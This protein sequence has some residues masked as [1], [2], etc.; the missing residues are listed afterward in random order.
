MQRRRVLITVLLAGAL[1]GWLAASDWFPTKVHAQ[2]N[3]AEKPATGGALVLPAPEAPFGG[4]IGRKAKE[5]KP[6]FPKAVT[7][8][9]GAPNVLLIM[10]DDTGFGASSTFGGPIPTP[11][12]E[13][14][15]QRGLR[16]N[17]FHTTALCSPTRAALLTGRNHHSVGF[18]DI[19][20]FATGFPGYN[21]IMP[22]SAGTIGNIL[23][24]NGYNTSWFGKNHLIPD[25]LES[26]DGPF[27]QW[28]SG[29]GFEYFYGF[30]GGDTDNWHPALFE[31]TKPVLPPF[32]DPNYIL[33]RDMTDRAINWIRTQHAIAPDK[34]FFL[35]FAPGNGHA[36][37]HAT[38]D[39]IAKF[40]GK[41][42]YGWDKQREMTLENQKKLGIV[43]PDTVLT[44]RPKEIPAWD[45]LNADQKR[46]YAR[47]MEVYAAAVAQS[48]YEIGRLID[49]LE[50]SGQLDNTLVIYIEGDNGASGEGTLQGT[51]NEMG[52]GAPKPESLPFLV[53]MMDQLGGDRT[54]NHYPVGWAHA[55]DTPFQWTKQVAS[56]FGG[57]RNGMAVSWP[58]RIKAHGEIRPQFHHVIDVLPTILEA[59]G[60][61]APMMLNGTS[62]MPFEGV[63]MAY[64]FDDGKAPMRHT[65]QYF[66]IAANRGLY[67]DGWMASTT[68]LRFP[69]VVSGV[70]PDPDAFPW[71]LYNV[72]QDFSQSNNLAKQNP[73]KLEELK[74]LFLI[75]A[76]R[77]N[78]LPIDSS[79]AD[80]ANPAL[81]PNFNTGRTEFT[82][83]PG[84]IRI[85]EANAPDIKNKSFQITADV[86][87]PQGGADG[88]IVTQGGRFG[89]WALLVLDHKP[90]F[91]YAFSNQD[92]DKYRYQEKYKTRI[93]ASEPLVPGKHAIVFDFAYDG[94]GAGKG[95]QGTLAVDGKKV[96]EGRIELT[97]ALRFSLDESFDVGQDTGS[98][99]I[100]EYDA[101][102]PFKFTGTLNRVEF[103]LS[104]E[105]L[106]TTQRASLQRLRTDF[107]LAVQ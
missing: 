45:S 38:R 49:S 76:A 15:A 27:D 96:A 95:G 25:W 105:N 100:D 62:Q 7:A 75:E 11:T 53:S 56:H 22:K 99:V 68:P 55:M 16:Y 47:M 6:D 36:P 14:I 98:P 85:P 58:A 91:A 90:M 72:A 8:P 78:V 43:P 44:P 73:E 1:L 33:I 3:A 82:Y 84:M 77:H 4:V 32:G 69:W 63:S 39:W 51:T 86:E 93:A 35:Y 106:T 89:G 59:T 34:P 37:H 64:T 46:V 74:S 30:L 9:K 40:K 102:M 24:G 71:E 88:V 28:P 79:F 57:T 23:V 10:T 83:Y 60:I 70:D 107:A 19:S 80:R 67:H 101:K 31:N 18:G 48:D 20:E 42:D 92:G 2:Q 65:T 17:N 29:M 50:A 97:Q 81:R 52:E 87:V 5:S 54:Y 21:S 104:P 13:R 94:G 26:P 12:L 66:E 41:F 61:Q 103:K